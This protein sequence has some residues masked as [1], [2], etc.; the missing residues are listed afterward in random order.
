MAG[1]ENKFS[2][3]DLSQARAFRENEVN[4]PE[5]DHGMEDD[6]GG[7][8]DG[9]RY[10]NPSF[11]GDTSNSDGASWQDTMN[12][13]NTPG[14]GGMPGMSG[15]DGM[16]NQ[17]EE[18]DYSDKAIDAGVTVAKHSWNVLKEIIK[19]FK[20]FD[21]DCRMS[22]GRRTIITGIVCMI[23]GLVILLLGRPVGLDIIFGGGVSL[24]VAI[25]VFM[26]AYADSKDKPINLME[27]E[28]E[29]SIPLSDEEPEPED[30]DDSIDFSD[31][32][33]LFDE[34][35]EVE[36][37]VIP[38]VPSTDFD[39]ISEQEF[40]D[41]D[42]VLESA[43]AHRNMVTRSY[44]F[45]TMCSVLE[46][47]HPD[48]ANLR[49]IEDGTS[50]F[51]S[52]NTSVEKAS[53]L[54][55]PNNNTDSIYLISA[56]EGLFY[57]TL[58]VKR[59]KWIKDLQ[60]F[61]N[62]LVKTYAFDPN[63]LTVDKKVTGTGIAV[64]DKFHIQ[65][66]KNLSGA[67]GMISLRDT[68]NVVKD[69]VLD[70]SIR[71][72]VVLGISSNG[73]V[74][75][76][77]MDKIYALLVTGMPRSG[78]S[79]LVLLILFQFMAYLPPSEL[80]FYFC[81]AKAKASD[82]YCINSPHVKGFESENSRILDLLKHLVDVEGSRRKRLIGEYKNIKSF[83]KANPDI[84]LPMIYVVID[85]VITLAA[86]MTEDQ[87]KELQEYLSIL[88]SQ[89]PAFGIRVFMVPHKLDNSI[90][91]KRTTDLIPCRVSVCGKPLDV[92]AT[93]GVKE[94]KFPYFLSNPGDI[95]INLNGVT[96]YVRA[97]VLARGDE[98]VNRVIKF[99]GSLWAKLEP[100]E[101]AGS[102]Y[103]RF[104]QA[105]KQSEL[106][107]EKDDTDRS[108]SLGIED[109]SDSDYADVKF[110]SNNPIEVVDLDKVKDEKGGSEDSGFDIW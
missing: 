65:I 60:A 31:P 7:E 52:W 93:C 81:D 25:C 106:L 79:W 51:D 30:D 91:K 39:S 21:A 26:Y 99:L 73:E 9:F 57:I 64:M 44:L 58:E 69:K 16:Q 56:D 68:Y 95:A 13:W 1:M 48:F 109:N 27:E 42:T 82:F 46:T 85:E 103:E 20:V 15:M 66:L 104:E 83:R 105:K 12:S 53:E 45:E 14:M 70:T 84:K 41:L 92:E 3:D 77:D 80:N 61:I 98:E 8:N 50:E 32:D 107:N 108:A 90:I 97:S 55:R 34:D 102:M 22:F 38:E 100:D 29:G 18:K 47:C 94:S 54:F 19:S 35:E 28:D 71:M 59:V 24:A 17:Q 78:K 2:D 40:T 37:E 49:H 76:E 75:F 5:H 62:E 33:I 67:N 96:S 88:V 86:S 72:P 101:C 63:T 36:V 89:L 11:S 23:A 74:V 43:E 4:P 10:D 110:H 87:S 6:F